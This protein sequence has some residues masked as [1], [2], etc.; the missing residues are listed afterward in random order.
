[1]SLHNFLIGDPPI[2]SAVGWHDWIG[3][4]VSLVS[5]N[6]ALEYWKHNGATNYLEVEYRQVVCRRQSWAIK[7]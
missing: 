2:G 5:E 4:S 6:L 7:L 1:M 3:E